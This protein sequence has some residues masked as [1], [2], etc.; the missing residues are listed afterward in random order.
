MVIKNAA[1]RVDIITVAHQTANCFESFS[2]FACK[3]LINIHDFIVLEK[4]KGNGISQKILK[5]FH[6]CG[7][8]CL[9]N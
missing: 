5:L 6:Y 7:T 1:I 9:S 4:Y 3:P 8:I 2:T